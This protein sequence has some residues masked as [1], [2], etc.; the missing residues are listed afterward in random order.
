ME[1]SSDAVATDFRC[2]LKKHVDFLGGRKLSENEFLV[3]FERAFQKLSRNVAQCKVSHG[4]SPMVQWQYYQY[5]Y[6]VS[7]EL[8]INGNEDEAVVVYNINKWLHG[9][10]LFYKVNL[11]SPFCSGHMQGAVLANI[12][13]GSHFVYFQSCTV[14]RSGVDKPILGR[15]VIMYPGSMILGRSQIGSNVVLSAG[16]KVINKQ[17]P[18]DCVVFESRSGGLAFK[19]LNEIYWKRFFLE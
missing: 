14:G 12:E 10:D 9:S 3:P 8:W 1:K 6:F 7:R 13:Y 18:D 15:G 19:A 5:L 17:V 2:L 4:F 11:P 16:V